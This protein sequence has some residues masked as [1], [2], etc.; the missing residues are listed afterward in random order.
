MGFQMLKTFLTSGNQR[1]GQ[2]QTTKNFEVNY[3]EYGTE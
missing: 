1:I 2:S 3:L